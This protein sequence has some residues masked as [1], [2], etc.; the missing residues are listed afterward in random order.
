MGSSDGSP[1]P[2][3]HWE[4]HGHGDASQT[5]SAVGRYRIAD[6]FASGQRHPATAPTSS[7]IESAPPH[8]N[9]GSSVGCRMRIPRLLDRGEVVQEV[10]H[11]APRPSTSEGNHASKA[12]QRH[13]RS[14][15]IAT[16]RRARSQRC[17]SGR[18]SSQSAIRCSQV[19][20]GR[21]NRGWSTYRQC[22]PE[23]PKHGCSARTRLA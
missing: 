19:C 7:R 5:L 10:D 23:R 12:A 14:S 15:G 3:N 4:R 17:H 16:E 9:P 8:E 21:A 22:G 1:K 6:R 20:L 18:Y 2:A 13:A 11:D